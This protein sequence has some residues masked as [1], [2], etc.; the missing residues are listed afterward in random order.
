VGA[1]S[2]TELG[3]ARRSKARHRGAALAAARPPTHAVP[4]GTVAIALACDSES[5]SIA[6]A[7]CPVLLQGTMILPQGAV[8]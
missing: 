1:A 8:L 3:G 6:V 5:I 4:L 2:L 7:S